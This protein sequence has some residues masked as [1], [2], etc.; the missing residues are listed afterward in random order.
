MSAEFQVTKAPQ[1]F[2]RRIRVWALA[3]GLYGVALALAAAGFVVL[4]H[5]FVHGLDVTDRAY[6]L[7]AAAALLSFPALIVWLHIRAKRTT[8][9]WLGTTEKGRQRTAQC[10]MRPQRRI[11]PQ[12]RS[13]ALFT[14]HWAN[15]TLRDPQSSIFKRLIAVLALILYAAAL[16]AII[17]A[18]ILLI[19]A[20][21][22]TFASLGWLMIL[23][24]LILLVLPAQ[25]ILALLRR[26]RSNGDL[27]S[28]P[29]DLAG[30]TA[31]RSQWFNQQRQQ[32]LRTKLISTAFSVTILTVWWL[33]VTVYHSRHPHESW[34]LPLFW[35]VTG[36]YLIWNQF[37]S[38]K[39]SPAK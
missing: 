39:S 3:C 30:I 18:S 31:A 33:R 13:L 12:Q 20:G 34:V 37:R 29:D 26:R 9:R 1:P 5:T 22:A 36:I 4:R 25:F 32:P 28:S 10:L 15:I 16:L 38:P 14:L 11:V 35:T 19:G 27:S 24:G 7:F 17:A 2:R 21:L 8:G 23:F 6:R